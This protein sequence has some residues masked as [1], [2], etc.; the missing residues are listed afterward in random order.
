MCFLCN[1]HFL[2]GYIELLKI[3]I[4]T[5][6]NVWFSIVVVVQD[7]CPSFGPTKEQCENLHDFLT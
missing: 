6:W 4:L 1:F 2:E 7:V 3:K 5:K